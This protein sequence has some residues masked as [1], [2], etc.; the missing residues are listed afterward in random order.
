MNNNKWI[1]YIQINT[2]NNKIE[3]SWFWADPTSGGCLGLRAILYYLF[4]H[5]SNIKSK[6]MLVM[7]KARKK[8]ET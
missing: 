1:K 8:S 4:P 2:H 7:K 3:N 5:M 6:N